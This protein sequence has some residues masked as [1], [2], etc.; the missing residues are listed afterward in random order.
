MIHA[1]RA[2]PPSLPHHPSR[3]L[4]RCI[5]PSHIGGKKL[6]S[7]AGLIKPGIDPR[8]SPGALLLLLRR[9]LPHFL[10]RVRIL[11]CS[12]VYAPLINAKIVGMR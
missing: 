8:R 1:P 10:R 6:P 4:R 7:F 11:I 9:L 12:R 5:F 3:R 2:Q